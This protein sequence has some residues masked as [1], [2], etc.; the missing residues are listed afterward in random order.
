MSLFIPQ[1]ET[2]IGIGWINTEQRS[3]LRG[4][5][6]YFFLVYRKY[7]KFQKYVSFS[8]GRKGAFDKLPVLCGSS[9]KRGRDV[10]KCHFTYPPRVGYFLKNLYVN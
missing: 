5:N 8:V 10:K 1:G 4:N 2:E 6:V 9:H 3:D 7:V